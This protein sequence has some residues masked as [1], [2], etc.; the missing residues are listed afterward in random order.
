MDREYLEENLRRS[1][2]S[3]KQVNQSAETYRRQSALKSVIAESR[4]ARGLP[5]VEESEL[6]LIVY[7]W[8][9]ALRDIPTAHLSA[10]YDRAIAD[11][12]EPEKPFGTPQL[13]KAW[14]VVQ[15]ERRRIEWARQKDEIS[16]FCKYCDGIGWQEL[17]DKPGHYCARPCACE[18]APASMRSAEPRGFPQWKREKGGRWWVKTTTEVL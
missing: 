11:Y 13:L 8:G 17:E 14:Q 5:L 7:S 16:T 3:G 1:A 9:K 4:K 2:E 15:D 18:A 6:L 12:T 10:C